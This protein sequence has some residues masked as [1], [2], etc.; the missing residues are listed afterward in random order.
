MCFHGWVSLWS[1]QGCWPSIARAG[2]KYTCR[3]PLLVEIGFLA[4]EVT[5]PWGR[6]P[7]AQVALWVLVTR[8]KELAW[9]VGSMGWGLS[10]TLSILEIYCISCRIPSPHSGPHKDYVLW[11]SAWSLPPPWSGLHKD[12]GIGL[13]LVCCPSQVTLCFS[14]RDTGKEL[15]H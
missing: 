9:V 6:V 4:L 3:Y 10:C 5:R 15:E 8:V 14:E 1:S 13:L 7:F 12:H 11:G 2:W